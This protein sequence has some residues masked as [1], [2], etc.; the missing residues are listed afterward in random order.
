MNE[1]FKSPTE[2]EAEIQ[3][4]NSDAAKSAKKETYDRTTVV[5]FGL[6]FV[7]PAII[8]VLS[9]LFLLPL[10]S[11]SIQEEPSGATTL[12]SNSGDISPSVR[13]PSSTNP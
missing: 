5:A 13:Q 2:I 11:H 8:I 1:P 6:L 4:A 12:R 9:M 3:A 7:L 10:I